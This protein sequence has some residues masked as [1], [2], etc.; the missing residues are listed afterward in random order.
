M[1]GVPKSAANPDKVSGAHE[2][3]PGIEIFFVDLIR[4]AGAL[5]AE[6]ARQPRL[7]VAD[8]ERAQAMKDENAGRIWRASR[9]A[10]R[11]A[12]ERVAGRGLRQVPFEIEPGGRP[13]VPGGG[14]Y[15]SISHTGGVALIA[16]SKEIAVGIDLERTERTLKM[17]AQRRSRV[18]TAAGR[19]PAQRTLSANTDA[20]VIAA[21]VR[22]EAAAKALGTGI[23]RLLTREGVVGGGEVP[24]VGTAPYAIAV[25]DLDIDPHHVGAIAAERLPEK[26]AIEN[27]SSET[28][29]EFLPS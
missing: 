7:S 17:S 8:V 16:V 21:W 18:V 6:E 23:G 22:L 12:L 5:E 11:I 3:P 2:A 4:M 29:D 24:E 20:D 9:I 26:L 19:F 10:T 27:V 15:F 28:F 25:R 14:A 13:V 1:Q